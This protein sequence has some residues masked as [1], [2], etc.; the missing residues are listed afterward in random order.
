MPAGRVDHR[1]GWKMVS[2]SK[3][4]DLLISTVTSDEQHKEGREVG[5]VF[6]ICGQKGMIANCW[7]FS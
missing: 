4:V 1:T 6:D 3:G 2:F 5:E 7:Y